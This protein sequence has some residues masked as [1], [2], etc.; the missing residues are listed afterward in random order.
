MYCAYHIIGDACVLFVFTNLGCDGVPKGDDGEEIFN[1]KH[2]ERSQGAESRSGVEESRIQCCV[3][4]RKI[5]LYIIWDSIT[6]QYH[7]FHIRLRFIRVW[8][9][10][11]EHFICFGTASFGFFSGNTTEGFATS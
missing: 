6:I 9:V 7:I 10:L 5:C 4:N 1:V 11:Y 3:C 8:L 2:T